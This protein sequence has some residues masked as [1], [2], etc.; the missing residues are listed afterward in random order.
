[1]H[2]GSSN[3]SA[4]HVSGIQIHVNASKTCTYSQMCMR[5]TLK[6]VHKFQVYFQHGMLREFE[7]SR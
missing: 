3:G 2:W 1:M 7:H 5:Y 6:P 4:G